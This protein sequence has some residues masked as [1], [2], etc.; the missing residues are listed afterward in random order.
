MKSK[1]LFFLDKKGYPV[2]VSS[3]LTTTS[4]LITHIK[5]T[6]HSEVY[7]QYLSFLETKTPSKKRKEPCENDDDLECLSVQSTNLRASTSTVNLKQTKLFKSGVTSI[8][9]YGINDI[10]QKTRHVFKHLYSLFFCVIILF[11]LS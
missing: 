7:Q 4:N 10:Q 6:S 9:K 3:S 11:V 2:W 5:T 8:K 1:K